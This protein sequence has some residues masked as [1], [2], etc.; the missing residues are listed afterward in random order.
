M[1]VLA[2]RWR[3]RLGLF[4]FDFPLRWEE[5]EEEEEELATEELISGRHSEKEG[6]KTN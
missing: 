1:V 4:T 2:G 3:D 5:E 6:S